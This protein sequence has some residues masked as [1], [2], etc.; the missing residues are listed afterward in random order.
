MS[1]LGKKPIQIPKGVE[2]TL[3]GNDVTVKGAKGTL[4]RVFST[5][6]SISVADEQITTIPNRNDKEAKAM[7]GTV[8]SHLQN[9]VDGVT[10]GYEKK[11]ILEGVGFKAE[12]KGK[13]LA[14]ALGFSH[15]VNVAIP[16]EL[17]VTAEKGLITVSGI[18]KDKVGQFAAGI[19]SLKKVEPYKGKGFHY[20]GEQVK[21]KQGKKTA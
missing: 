10:T 7:W 4:S 12:I 15:P 6:V 14:M 17:T 13:E 5:L 9:M 11:L 3:N 8:S 1:R 21:R 20:E 16:E 19:K 18:N 2:V